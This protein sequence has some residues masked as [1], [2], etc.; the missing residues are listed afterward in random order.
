M[1][2]K[3]T[4]S[5]EHWA[6]HGGGSVHWSRFLEVISQESSPG[7]EACSLS[8]CARRWGRQT[9]NRAPAFDQ[10]AVQG[11]Q[12]DKSQLMLRVYAVEGSPLSPSWRA[13]GGFLEDK[14]GVLTG[15]Q[16]KGESVPGRKKGVS[17]AWEHGAEDL[18]RETGA[19]FHA[20]ETYGDAGCGRGAWRGGESLSCSSHAL[21]ESSDFRLQLWGVSGRF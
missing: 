19:A 11:T 4:C 18:P 3:G 10:L 21:G 5:A 13:K 1:L 17:K 20:V 6:A 14:P 9:N 12:V 15:E 16:L 8:G 2:V 7:H